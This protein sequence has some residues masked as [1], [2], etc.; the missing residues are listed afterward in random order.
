MLEHFR[1]A[2]FLS[3][4]FDDVVLSCGGTVARLARRGVPAYILTIFGGEPS[5]PLS[6]FARWQHRSRGVDDTTVVTQR[7]GEE[8][9]AAQL[10]G[11]EAI[12]FD[13]PDAIYRGTR[14]SSDEELFGNPHPDDLDLIH[15][16]V[17]ALQALLAPLPTPLLLCAP[18]GV[19]N[20]VDHQLTRLVALQLADS[21]EYP[22]TSPGSNWG[23]LWAYEELPY[24]A[25]RQ[26]AMMLPD[27][28]TQFSTGIPISVPLDDDL[29]RKR[30][31]AV[32]CYQSQ[33]S[34]IFRELGD[35]EMVIGDYARTVGNQV[36]AE[37]FWVIRQLKNSHL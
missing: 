4:H 32:H 1:T 2:V 30:I 28:V 20:H 22:L 18:L 3:P 36:M 14:Y 25:S 26:G 5:E 13:V 8:V 31:Q 10:L 24:A 33:L 16:F 29:F 23:E 12:W 34:F 19:G 35:P 27:L 17:R 11:A 9:C 37:R 6:D 15:D 21:E 7:R